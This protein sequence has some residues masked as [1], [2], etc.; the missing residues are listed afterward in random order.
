MKIPASEA[1]VRKT[2]QEQALAIVKRVDTEPRN[3]RPSREFLVKQ[4]S[5]GDH[6]SVRKQSFADALRRVE[7]TL[8]PEEQ[9][10][11]ILHGKIEDLRKDTD[12][13]EVFS[14]GGFGSG[15]EGYVDAATGKLT[16]LWIVPEG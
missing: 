10:T 13:W 14:F 1:E 7:G 12:C 4:V 16:F 9:K 3:G 6:L 2:F 8:S 11:L 15:V 5:D